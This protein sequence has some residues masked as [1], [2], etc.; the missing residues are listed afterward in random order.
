M[1]VQRRSE[2]KGWTVFRVW[3]ACFNLT[4]AQHLVLLHGIVL[5]NLKIIS[6]T[7]NDLLFHCI[8]FLICYCKKIKRF[9]TPLSDSCC[10]WGLLFASQK[11]FKIKNKSLQPKNLVKISLS[12]KMM[13]LEENNEDWHFC[14]EN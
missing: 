3:E 9:S 7:E 4:H 10:I 13:Y 6:Q 1:Y 8:Q 2:E 12:W 14:F 11:Y 5:T